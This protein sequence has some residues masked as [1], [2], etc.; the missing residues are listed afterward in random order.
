VGFGPRCP[1]WGLSPDGLN[2][3]EPAN[4]VLEGFDTEW[5]FAPI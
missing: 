3:L 2:V 4:V 1:N 5:G